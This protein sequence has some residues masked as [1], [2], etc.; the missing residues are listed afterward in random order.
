[1]IILARIAA[2]GFAALTT[3]SVVP[4]HAADPAPDDYPA[5]AALFARHCAS[6]HTLGDGARMGPDLAGVTLRRPSAWLLRWIDSP[7]A[8]VKTDTAA[9]ALVRQWGGWVM[10]DLD[11][12]GAEILDIVDFLTAV[13]AGEVGEDELASI[14]PMTCPMGA[15]SGSGPHQH[16]PGGHGAGHGAGPGAGQG[17]GPG[18]GHA[19]RH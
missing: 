12:T 3:L 6:C 15:M 17:A 11:L 5:G 8:V 4:R 16:G 10:P 9:A 1:M 19:C 18:P 14:A 2:I 13:D 7:S